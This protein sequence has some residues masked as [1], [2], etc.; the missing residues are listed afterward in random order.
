MHSVNSALC[1]DLYHVLHYCC[2]AAC[3]CAVRVRVLTD[4]CI[5][6]AATALGWPGVQR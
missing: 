6:D 2:I 1:I 5:K 4:V 3:A